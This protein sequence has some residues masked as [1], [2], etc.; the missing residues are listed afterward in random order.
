MRDVQLDITTQ[1][2]HK[3]FIT[4]RHISVSV[5]IGWYRYRK[6]ELLMIM[7]DF[8]TTNSNEWPGDEKV[9]STYTLEFS[10]GWQPPKLSASFDPRSR[11]VSRTPTAKITF[12]AS[13]LR[14]V[15]CNQDS[16]CADSDQAEPESTSLAVRSAVST[17]TTLLNLSYFNACVV[18][19]SSD[20][21]KQ[22][23][24]LVLYDFTSRNVKE[25]TVR[26]G[27]IVT[28]SIRNHNHS[29]VNRVF[30]LHCD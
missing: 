24:M 11:Q 22:L 26:K 16:V 13:T 30:F 29:T 25:L 1:I 2:I 20:M 18:N 21:S 14:P 4:L 27:D 5:D 10:D 19:Y 23:E 15:E 12:Q 3:V 8:A 17:L 7:C 9:I 28:V 6:L